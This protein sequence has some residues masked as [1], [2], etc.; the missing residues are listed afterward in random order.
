MCTKEKSLGLTT[1]TGGK[2]EVSTLQT[3]RPP[4]TTTS[5]TGTMPSEPQQQPLSSSNNNGHTGRRKKTVTFDSVTVRHYPMTLGDHPMCSYGVP[6][7]LD[8]EYHERG[9]YPV[10]EYEQAFPQNSNKK[11]NNNKMQQMVLTH[12]QRC[13]I[14]ERAGFSDEEI[15]RVQHECT[16][17]KRQ[18]SKTLLMSPANQVQEA[19]QDMGEKVTKMLK[20]KG[21]REKKQVQ[22]FFDL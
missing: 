20:R 9:V 2:E 6:V 12:Y 14:L 3:T 5:P 8:W 21:R 18:R 7:Q 19:V 1:T 10:D 15:R 17:L 13:G 11:K 22:A 4:P 16:C